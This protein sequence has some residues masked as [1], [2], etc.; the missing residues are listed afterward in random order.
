MQIW[1]KELGNISD[2]SKMLLDDDQTVLRQFAG[3]AF[4]SVQSSRVDV[5]GPNIRAMPC[6][7]QIL[8]F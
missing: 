5:A 2:R 3:G 4:E 6:N 7:T 1:P 8:Y